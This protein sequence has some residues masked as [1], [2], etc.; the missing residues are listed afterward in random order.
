MNAFRKKRLFMVFDLVSGNVRF[1]RMKKTIIGTEPFGNRMW[2]VT[3]NYV[4]VYGEVTG[5]YLGLYEAGLWTGLE[6][7][8]LREGYGLPCN[9]NGNH[10]RL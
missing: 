1:P 4:P 7:A 5:E 8:N 3:D 6:L 2:Y 9:S 10:Y